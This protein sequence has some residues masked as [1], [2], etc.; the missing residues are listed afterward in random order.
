MENNGDIAEIMAHI[1]HSTHEDEPRFVITITSLIAKGELSSTKTWEKSVKDEK[2]KLARK[3][4]GEKEAT[5]AEDL[6]RELGVWE[7]FFGSGKPTERKK[8]SKG[9]KK[10][11]DTDEGE[12]DVSALQAL[13]RKKQERNMDGFFDGLAAKYGGASKSKGKK[14]S[15]PEDEDEEVEM[16]KKKARS[17]VPPPPEISEEEFARIQAQVDSKRKSSGSKLG[18]LKSKL[19]AKKTK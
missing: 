17:G 18:K 9:S 16:P 10:R 6:A 3:R 12:G 7:E 5:E 13:I 15:R 11:D 8:A 2:A 4:A 14:R 1:P 19:K